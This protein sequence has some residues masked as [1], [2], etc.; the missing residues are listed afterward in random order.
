MFPRTTVGGV[1]VSRMVVGTNWFLGWSHASD[2]KDQLIRDVVRDRAR[3]T[4]ILATFFRAG[5]DTVMGP[6]PHPPLIEAVRDAEQQAGVKAILISTPS[7][8]VTPDLPAKG[9]DRGEVARILDEQRRIGV[10]ICMPHQSTTDALVDRCTRT[11]RHADT[12]CALMR[13]R[14]L[15]PGLSSHMPETIIYADDTGLDVETYISIFNVAGFLMQIEVDWT[16]QI[17]AQAAKPV[18]TIKPFAAGQVRP[19]Q[20]LTFSWNAIRPTDMVAVGTMSVPEAQ[21][22]IDLSLA[23]LAHQSGHTKLQET[24]SKQ[25]VKRVLVR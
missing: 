7:F 9:F 19:L 15:I 8:P 13:E 16:A 20:G 10:H 6:F 17:I 18:I 23:I 24:R 1:S 22:C 5:I 4:E 2:A 14:G 12:L 11:I 3:I 21:E 25:S